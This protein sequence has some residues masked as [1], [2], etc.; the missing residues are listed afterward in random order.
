MNAYNL[1]CRIH[2]LVYCNVCKNLLC[3]ECLNKTHVKD[4]LMYCSVHSK[5]IKWKTGALYTSG[6]YE[7]IPIEGEDP[8][9]HWRTTYT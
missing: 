1:C 4:R 7:L 5:D 3:E 9:S 8:S 2:T 6:H